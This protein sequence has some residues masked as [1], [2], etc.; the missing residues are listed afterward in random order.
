VF[1]AFR[2]KMPTIIV[3]NDLCKGCNLCVNACAKHLLRAG[4]TSNSMGY[5]IV[6]LIEAEKCSGC[7]LCAI[8]C[9][10]AAIEVYK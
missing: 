8:M 2:R 6:E 9:P 4:E 3:V 7:K 5:R 1:D 10:D